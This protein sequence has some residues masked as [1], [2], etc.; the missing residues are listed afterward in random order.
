MFRYRYDEKDNL[1]EFA[2]F[3]A[4]GKPATDSNNIHKYTQKFN[5]RNQCIETCYYD[6]KGELTSYSD[7][8]YCIERYEYDEKGQV[9]KVSYFDKNSQP[10]IYYGDNDGH[11]S[12]R[13]IEYDQYGRTI[14]NFYFDKNGIPTDPKVMVPEAVCDYDKWG[15]MNYVASCDGKGNLIM[16]PQTGWSYMKQE[17]DNKGNVLWS[18]YFNDKEKPMLCKDGYHKVVNTYTNSNN[19]ESIS[20][21][22]TAEKPMLING[23]HKEV[24]KYNEDDL[25]IEQAHFGKTGKPV[26]CADGFSK[27]VFTYNKDHSVRD[28]KYYSA[29]GKML[30]HEQYI[31]GDWVRVKN[32]QKD[33]SD[34]A[35]ELPLDLGED[36]GNLVIQSAKVIG[37]SKVE[38]VMVAPKSKYDMANYMIEA[39]KQILEV[40]TEDVKQQLEIPRNVTV[41]GILKDSKGRELSTVNK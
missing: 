28:R 16:N 17:Y 11:Y 5:N 30:L 20:Y 39:Y 4:E 33:V 13:T 41:K 15:N 34:F 9:I 25:C 27:V 19:M 26:D 14:K 23:Y 8:N 24:H 31:N 35:D 22:D 36:A 38:I 40:I 10:T 6:V 3:D 29:S 21:F 18:A 32:W 37:S 2:V 1:I 7:H 12:I